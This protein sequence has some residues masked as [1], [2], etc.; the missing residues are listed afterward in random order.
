M[1][2]QIF[3]IFGYHRDY[4][5]SGKYVGHVRLDQPDRK[6]FSYAGRICETLQTP[7]KTNRMT[8][9][10]GAVVTHE[11]IPLCGKINGSTLGERISVLADYY[12]RVPYKNRNK[13]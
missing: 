2:D 4:W 9:P 7:V 12:N 6:T 13:Q 3:N 8:I 5:I 10:A 11:C 1:Q